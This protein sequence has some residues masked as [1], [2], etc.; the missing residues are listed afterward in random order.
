[1]PP[2]SSKL[3]YSRWLG[4]ALSLLLLAY[5]LAQQNWRAWPALLAQAPA[6]VF[7][8]AWLAYVAGMALNGVR[9]YWVARAVDLPLRLAEAIRWTFVSAFVSNVLPSTIGGDMV[10]IA[11]LAR[12]SNRWGLAIASAMLDRLLKMA[13]MLSASPFTLAAFGGWSRLRGLFLTGGVWARFTS[14]ERWV[15]FWHQTANWRRRPGWLL[16]AF[17]LAWLSVLPYVF[18]T[19]TI[20]RGLGIPVSMSQVLGAMVVSYF[21]TLL[22]ISVNGWGLREV[23]IIRLYVALGATPEQASLLA[24][25]TRVLMFT[26]S[27]LG[28]LAAP[29]YWRDLV[30]QAPQE[31]PREGNEPFALA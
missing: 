14:R 31:M 30:Q 29:R 12:R 3:R 16:S 9:W 19:W 21:I 24:L 7:L 5:V 20:A 15:A 18:A 27:L 1:M 22:P 13:V 4:T 11:A 28:G 25:S 26:V 17:G 10:R 6:G 2:R 8:A 23:T